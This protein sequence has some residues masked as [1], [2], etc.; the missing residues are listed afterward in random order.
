MA[1]SM[2]LLELVVLDDDGIDREAGLEFD[3]IDRVQVGRIG[4]PDEQALAAPEQ[5]Q[6]T[7]LGQQLVGYRADGVE[8]DAEGIE[9]QHRHAIL[10]RGRDGDVARLGG[11][12]AESAE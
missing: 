9:I 11:A 4:D 1:L 12:G 6:H 2:C 7:M 8:I 10:A 5:R 3:L